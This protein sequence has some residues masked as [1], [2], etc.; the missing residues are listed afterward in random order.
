MTAYEALEM[1][2]FVADRTPSSQRDRVGVFYGTT[3]DDWREVRERGRGK[4]PA[5]ADMGGER[6][7]TP[8][9]T[10]T[11]ISSQ[12]EIAPSYPGGSGELSSC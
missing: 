12:A 10:S 11:R 1:A 6:R 9:K 2:G 8:G 3:S 7:S 5:Y 4:L